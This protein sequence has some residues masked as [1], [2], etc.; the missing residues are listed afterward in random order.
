M[1]QHGT[2][3]EKSI[4]VSIS[5]GKKQPQVTSRNATGLKPT[6]R[7]ENWPTW[8]ADVSFC[9]WQLRCQ[10]PAPSTG[11]Q[12]TEL[13]FWCFSLD[14]WPAPDGSGDSW[15]PEGSELTVGRTF[16]DQRQLVL[17][18]LWASTVRSLWACGKPVLTCSWWVCWLQPPNWKWI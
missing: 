1:G 5:N 15:T 18:V 2:V 16:G 4:Q 10:K 9:S 8:W 7:A 12:Q 14:S 17:K 3:F 6:G 13:S 11:Q